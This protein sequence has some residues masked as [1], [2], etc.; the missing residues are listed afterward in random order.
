M[1]L[2]SLMTHKDA[3]YIQ[4]QHLLFR[5]E[6]AMVEVYEALYVSLHVRKSNRAALTLYKDTLGFR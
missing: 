6:K 1:G 2:H 4:T 5:I 3:E